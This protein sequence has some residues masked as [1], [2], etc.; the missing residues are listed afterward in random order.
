G[1]KEGKA[2]G[3]K[4]GKEAG[5]QEG[6]RQAICRMIKKGFDRQTIMELGYTELEYEEA[7]ASETASV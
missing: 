6:K 3:I 2:A 5:L 7:E 4:E 1:I